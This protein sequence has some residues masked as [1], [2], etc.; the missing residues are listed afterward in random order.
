M[1]LSMDE[2]HQ[3]AHRFHK[4][5]NRYPRR[6][7]AGYDGERARAVTNTDTDDDVV[8]ETVAA[9]KKAQGLNVSY[10]PDIGEAKPRT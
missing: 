4:V 7:T 1:V 6:G 8:T 5:G 3:H 10:W 9:W 2:R